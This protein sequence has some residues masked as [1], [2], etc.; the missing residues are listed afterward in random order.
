[1]LATNLRTL[2]DHILEVEVIKK[3]LQV[4][5][6]KL[7]QAAVSIE[8]FMDL[9]VAKV[10]DVIGRLRVFEE[11]TKPKQ[12]TDA[13]GRLMLCEEDWEARRKERRE[14]G[15]SIGAS[16][17]GNRGKRQ[18]RGRGRG[19]RNGQNNGASKPPPGD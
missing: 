5:P 15:N 12:I 3:L 11:R 6:E 16:G 9:K 2:R 13:M 18:A 19:G 17:S 14:E 1:V 7:N 8:M 4:V 10:E